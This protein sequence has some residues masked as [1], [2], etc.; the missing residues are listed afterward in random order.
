[1]V[2][3]RYTC[4]VC[5]QKRIILIIIFNA[6]TIYWYFNMPFSSGDKVLI[7]NVYQ[8][9]IYSFQKILLEFLKT[10]LKR[11]ILVMLI[12]KIWKTESTTKSMRSVD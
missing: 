9:K 3:S 5:K 2:N 4:D 7:K 10:Y 1:M 11:K 12:T 6:V 8:F